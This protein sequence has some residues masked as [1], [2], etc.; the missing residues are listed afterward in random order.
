MDV[1]AACPAMVGGQGPCS[2]AADHPLHN[3]PIHTVQSPL[4]VTESYRTY[5]RRVPRRWAGKDPAAKPQIIRSKNRPIH[6]V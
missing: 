6:T 1:L 5:L 3:H 4:K 2:Q